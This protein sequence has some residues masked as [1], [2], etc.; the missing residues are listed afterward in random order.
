MHFFPKLSKETRKLQIDGSVSR[1]RRPRSAI[2]L[3]FPTRESFVKLYEIFILNFV[4]SSASNKRADTL[5]V[6]VYKGQAG[7]LTLGSINAN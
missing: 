2:S 6:E 4:I 1:R 7:M 5:L 3:K